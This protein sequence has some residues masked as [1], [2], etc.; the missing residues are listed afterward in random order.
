MIREVRRYQQEGKD[1]A[2]E[3]GT[4]EGGDDDDADDEEDNA[5][6]TDRPEEPEDLPAQHHNIQV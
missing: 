2:E 5:R 6:K 3:D 1:I 4:Q